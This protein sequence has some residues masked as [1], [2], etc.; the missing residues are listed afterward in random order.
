MPCVTKWR[1]GNQPVPCGG[2]GFTRSSRPAAW[3][4]PV[5]LRLPPLLPDDLVAGAAEEADN[6]L[7]SL[8]VD[9][10]GEGQRLVDLLLKARQGVGHAAGGRR[11]G[12][13]AGLFRSCLLFLPALALWI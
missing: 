9:H 7:E 12:Q 1:H 11:A 10:L 8:A 3:G 5:R 2:S 6:V 4:S 13:G